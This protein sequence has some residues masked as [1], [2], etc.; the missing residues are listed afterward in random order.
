MIKSRFL[1]LRHLNTTTKILC[2]FAHF[3]T[4]IE[5]PKRIERQLLGLTLQTRFRKAFW[6][7]YSA[8]V[9]RKPTI[10]GVNETIEVACTKGFRRT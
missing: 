1:S 3:Y 5:F 4:N 2:G 7:L 6:K 8:D 9:Q 10:E